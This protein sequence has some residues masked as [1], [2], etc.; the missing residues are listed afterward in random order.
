MMTGATQHRVARLAGIDQGGLSRIERGLEGYPSGRRLGRI[1]V[2]LD[3]LSGGGDPAGPWANL[4]AIRPDELPHDAG[5][6]P[7]ARHR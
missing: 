1:V 3:W 7:P 6:R 4:E 5:P 2:V